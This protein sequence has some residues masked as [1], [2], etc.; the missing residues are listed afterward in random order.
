[1]PYTEGPNPVW[2]QGPGD[3]MIETMEQKQLAALQSI[4][5]SLL[6]IKQ[7]LANSTSMT[8]TLVVETRPEQYY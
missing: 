8:G 6:E 3:H 4:A 2:Y 1:M 7:L 5:E